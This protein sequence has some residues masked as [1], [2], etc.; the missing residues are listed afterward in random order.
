MA[1][2]KAYQLLEAVEEFERGGPLGDLV[3]TASSIHGLIRDDDLSRLIYAYRKRREGIV[4]G[5]IVRAVKQALVN[6]GVAR[7]NG[8]R[9]YAM[10]KI[11]RI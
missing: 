4:V 11:T 5:D 6:K 10:S 9:V 3:N 1:N 2:A 8:R 7:S